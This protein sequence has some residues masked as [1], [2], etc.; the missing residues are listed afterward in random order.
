MIIKNLEELDVEVP[1]LAVSEITPGRDWRTVRR[2]RDEHRSGV[3]QLGGIAAARK[4]L[5][6][7]GWM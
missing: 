5:L 4:S 6:P 1:H 7:V 3:P 2:Y